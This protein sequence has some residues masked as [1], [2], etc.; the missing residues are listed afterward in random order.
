MLMKPIGRWHEKA[1]R[2]P[3]DSDA[4]PPFLPKKRI[5]FSRENHD[6]RARPVSVTSRISTGRIL[7][8]MSAHRI[9][10]KVEPDSRGS[11][12]SQTSILEAKVSHVREKI[13]LPCPVARDFS[14]LSIVIALFTIEPVPE[15]K[16]V[17][18]NEVEIPETVDHLGRVSEREKAG[19]LGSLC[20]EVLVPSV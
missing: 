19:G 15:F 3:F 1:I 17:A 10:G 18:E 20:V 6:M 4:G 7:F 12:T 14:S 13:G 2:T 16:A 8:E 5:A 11:L 9:G